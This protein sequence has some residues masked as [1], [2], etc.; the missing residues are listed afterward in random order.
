MS[1]YNLLVL[2]TINIPMCLGLRHLFF[3]NWRDFVDGMK[4]F[5][6]HRNLFFFSGHDYLGEYCP[7]LKFVFFLISC[8][9]LIMGELYFFEHWL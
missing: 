8:A 4:M 3:K 2:M 5:H 1:Q 9:C 7:E 6:Q